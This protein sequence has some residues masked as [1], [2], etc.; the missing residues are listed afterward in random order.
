MEN[1]YYATKKELTNDSNEG[2][3]VKIMNMLSPNRNKIIGTRV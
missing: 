2:Y 1:E 3:Y